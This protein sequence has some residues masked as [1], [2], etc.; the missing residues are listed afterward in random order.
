VGGVERVYDEDFDREFDVLFAIAEGVARRILGSAAEAEDVASEALARTLVRWREVRNLEHR[1]AW[2]AKTATNL[3]I[4]AVRRR[5]RRVPDVV[6]LGQDPHDRTVL[7]RALTEALAALPRRQRE[8]IVL[9][10]LV[11][12]PERDVAAAMHISVNS[13]K[14]HAHRGLAHLRSSE[15]SVIDE[16]NDDGP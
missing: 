1:E 6:E 5:R 15:V 7:R 13:V 16:G 3:A 14:K 11:G 2:V 12:L 9:R 8:A 10:H 4:D